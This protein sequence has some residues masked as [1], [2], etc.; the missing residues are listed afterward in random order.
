MG[1]TLVLSGEESFGLWAEHEPAWSAW[2]AVSSQWRVAVG[3]LGGA[4]WLGLDFAAARVGLDLAGLQV[5]PQ[6]WTEMRLIEAGAQEEL[7]RG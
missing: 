3:G 4:V 1:I 6:V 5:S 7:N 2:C